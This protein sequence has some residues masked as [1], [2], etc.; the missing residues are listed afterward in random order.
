VQEVGPARDAGGC[1]GFPAKGAAN[2]GPVARAPD[3]TYG[4]LARKEVRQMISHK[5]RALAAAVLFSIVLVDVSPLRLGNGSR[6][7][8]RLYKLLTRS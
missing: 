4:G 1:T 2:R 3:L 5:G 7:A 6:R 8:R